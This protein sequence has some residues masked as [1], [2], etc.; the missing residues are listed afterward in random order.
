M[1]ILAQQSLVFNRTIFY[2]GGMKRTGFSSKMGLW[3]NAS[4][5]SLFILIFV[6]GCGGSADDD[7]TGSGDTEKS[8]TRKPA[9]TID[10][11]P[12]GSGLSTALVVRTFDLPD[13]FFE[14][15]FARGGAARQILER[16]GGEF[17]EGM[18]ARFDRSAGT[19]EVKATESEL[20]VVEAVVDYWGLIEEVK[21][22]T[23]W[24]RIQKLEE[25]LRDIVIPEVDFK[26]TPLE[27]A[28]AYLEQTGGLAKVPNG[29]G[30][31]GIA[32]ILDPPR[33]WE[34]ESR[35]GFDTPDKTSHLPVT[36]K[37]SDVPLFEAL[38]F[39][40]SL[41]QRKYRIEETEIRVGYLDLFD[42]PHFVQAYLAPPEMSRIIAEQSPPQ[43]DDPFI[44]PSVF[45]TPFVP[46]ARTYLKGVYFSANADVHFDPLRNIVIVKGGADQ[47]REVADI[48]SAL[49]RVSPSREWLEIQK[50]R[51]E[52]KLDTIVLPKSAYENI[53]IMRMIDSIATQSRLVDRSG[54]VWER[55]LPIR[56]RYTF[57]RNHPESLA[58]KKYLTAF[59]ATSLDLSCLTIRRAI[60]RI[61]QV[62]DAKI[63]VGPDG[64]ELSFE[65]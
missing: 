46:T 40:V 12:G 1:A 8:E 36:L 24:Q 45:D 41:A 23:R 32:I 16:D 59:K 31:M 19:L 61:C 49:I 33:Q 58:S 14:S 27:E 29:Q 43:K 56:F 37:L 2:V 62:I 65:E 52:S 28:L 42:E 11:S 55:G 13:G 50:S 44:D 4:L 63:S 64:V 26:E 17:G 9:I 54:P 38:R 39:T 51:F 47:H 3:V 30:T 21:V 53:S 57:D 7:G 6:S 34:E 5:I 10:P 35:Y 25:R 18:E 48:L 15:D 22:E 60:E 20:W